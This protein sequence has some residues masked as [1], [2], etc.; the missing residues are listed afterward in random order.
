MFF[1][2]NYFVHSLDFFCGVGFQLLLFRS[3]VPLYTPYI[4]RGFLAP[5]FFG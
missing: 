3:S 5:T 2:K 4:L 1:Y